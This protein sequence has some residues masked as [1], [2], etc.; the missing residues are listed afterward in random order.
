MHSQLA[1]IAAKLE[2]TD[3]QRRAERARH[4][5][6]LPMDSRSRLRRGPRAMLARVGRAPAAEPARLPCSSADALR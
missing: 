6:D 1:H 4:R 2:T 5:S 3:H